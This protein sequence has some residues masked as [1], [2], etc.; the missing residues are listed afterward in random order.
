MQVYADLQVLSARP[1][2]EEMAGI[3]HHLYGHVAAD[4]AY[5]VARYRED[6]ASILDRLRVLSRPA[7]L[8]GGSGLYFRALTEGLVDTPAVP[9]EVRDEVARRVA[10]VDE[11]HHFL[12]QVDAETAARLSTNDTPRIQRA[13]EVFLTTGLSL[14]EWQ[15]TTAKPPLLAPGQWRGVFLAPARDELYRRIN[16]RFDAMLTNGAIDEARALLLRGLP[17]NVGIMK[18]H[19][20]KHLIE[21]LRGHMTLDDACAH[22]QRDTRNYAKRQFTWARRFMADWDWITPADM[23]ERMVMLDRWMQHG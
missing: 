1:T 9:S 8:V 21:Y 13:L 15:R 19:G 6:V 16:L 7:V 23:K 5:T 2:A 11:A 4:T 20:L 22:G 14:S 17:G 10:R 18:A 12:M 3:P